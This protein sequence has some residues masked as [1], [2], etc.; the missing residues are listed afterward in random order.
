MAR[1]S[2]VPFLAA[3][4]DDSCV[5]HCY[6]FRPN[7]VQLTE[8]L[9]WSSL[10]S[11]PGFSLTHSTTPIQ[12]GHKSQAKTFDFLKPKHTCHMPQTWKYF[13]SMDRSK[14][15]RIL[16]VNINCQNCLCP[17]RIWF[18]NF[19]FVPCNKTFLTISLQFQATTTIQMNSISKD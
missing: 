1:P 10:G 12:F 17:L 3:R 16:N 9:W 15:S 5:T 13:T 4:A 14:C 11:L 19:M 8:P 6:S 7:F 2:L 18:I